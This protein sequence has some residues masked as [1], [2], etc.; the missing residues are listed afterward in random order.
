MPYFDHN[1][2]SPLAAV[3]RE[4]WLRGHE[5]NWHHPSGLTRASARARLRLD[6]YAEA[7]AILVGGEAQDYVFNSG[8]TE[9]AHTVLAAWA[10]RLPGGARL[11]A[12]RTEHAC[13]LAALARYFPGRV[14][15]L[16]HD[17]HGR[18]S[19]ATAHAAL[20][21]G[22]AGLVV[23]AANNETGVLQP[24]AELAA[25]AQ[26]QGVPYLC[27]ATQWLGR[28]PA[29]GLGGSGAWLIASA[30]KFGGPRG[31][32]WVK[33]PPDARDF[34]P[35][36]ETGRKGPGRAGTEDVPAA[37]ALCAALGE[38]ERRHVMWESQRLV[39]RTRF[40]ERLLAALP[41]TQIVARPA[42]RLWNTV[43]LLAPHGDRARW[44]A[45]LEK[46]GCLVSSGAACA[47]GQ[48]GPSHVLAALGVPPEA[49]TRALRLSA[50]WATSEADWDELL[51]AIVAVAAELKS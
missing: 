24:W 42:E 12:A 32:G 22:A 47:S 15:W 36:G 16:E 38:A 44:I 46:R 26:R 37:A 8:A 49:A 21:A 28:L 1:A 20:A 45:R 25:L 31:C 5:E 30:H 13:V 11:A 3:A 41:G 43:A 50:A 6:S 23:M 19:A 35:W 51:T 27:D 9:G 33:T 17:A 2:T 48:A 39:W 14:D 4:A 10:A 40:E 18:I 7:L 29:A 34:F